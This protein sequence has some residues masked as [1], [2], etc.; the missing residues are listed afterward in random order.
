MLYV[1]TDCANMN[2]DLLIATLKQLREIKRPKVTLLCRVE[3]VGR[4]WLELW[5]NLPRCRN[6]L[7]NVC[8]CI[9]RRVPQQVVPNWQAETK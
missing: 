5:W 2:H 8:M 1:Y 9:A 6:T 7:L 4:N 3:L